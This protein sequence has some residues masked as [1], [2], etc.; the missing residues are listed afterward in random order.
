M[1]VRVRVRAHRRVGA[2]EP[3]RE[4]HA[5]HVIKALLQLLH[6]AGQGL[7]GVIQDSPWGRMKTCG[8][9]AIR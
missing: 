6:A 4:Q 1:R 3:P 7:G 9:S 8:A 2:G 5:A